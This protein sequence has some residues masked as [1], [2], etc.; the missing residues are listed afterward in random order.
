LILIF[1]SRAIQK[2]RT[3]RWI[4]KDE[5]PRTP[6]SEESKE[7]LSV[8]DQ[9]MTANDLALNENPDEA[10]LNIITGSNKTYTYAG[11]KQDLIERCQE[12]KDNPKAGKKQNTHYDVCT[13]VIAALETMPPDKVPVMAV[14]FKEYL[15]AHKS[16]KLLG[17]INRCL[18]PYLA[19][20][21]EQG[22]R[23]NVNYQAMRQAIQGQGSAVADKPREFYTIALLGDAGVGKT[24]LAK[25]W[26][27]D[28]FSKDYNATIGVEFLI[29]SLKGSGKSE[30]LRIWDTS[31]AE[32]F[33]ALLSTYIEHS[34]AIFICFDTTNKESFKN[35]INYLEVAR[36]PRDVQQ[37]AKPPA[38]TQ[39]ATRKNAPAIFLVGT[40][41]DMEAERDVSDAEVTTFT[42][43]QNLPA[44][45][46]TSAKTTVNVAALFD[47]LPE[48]L[49][50]GSA[51][52][53]SQSPRGEL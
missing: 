9:F 5:G 38:A 30:K 21:D 35:V 12:Y 33:K 24:A 51:Q 41:A 14:A 2:T 22:L 13:R 18:T 39:P 20:A 52:S 19:V 34:D 10:D 15:M 11:L 6:D 48:K 4:S 27:H 25:R 36:A 16:S 37:L 31:G 3:G 53:P 17:S 29:K 23:N 47:T 7:L 44:C 1:V 49:S 50:T 26:V 42:E 45:L 40:K 8:I 43:A 46:Y 32:R 28:N